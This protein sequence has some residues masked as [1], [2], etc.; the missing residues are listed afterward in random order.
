MAVL[1]GALGLLLLASASGYALLSRRLDPETSAPER[2][3]LYV[4]VGFWAAAFAASLSWFVPLHRYGLYDPPL[5]LAA[6]GIAIPA[7]SWLRARRLPPVPHGP[8]TTSDRLVLAA[9]AVVFVLFFLGIS[10]HHYTEG[11]L[12]SSLDRLSRVGTREDLPLHRLA[13]DE[14]FGNV[15]A[16]WVVSVACPIAVERL[17]QGFFAALLFLSAAA[18]GRRLTGRNWPG[19]AAGAALVLTDDVFGFEVFNQNLIGGS[20][21]MLLFLSLSRPREGASA[22]LPAFLAA[23][24]VSSRYIALAGMAVLGDAAVRAVP[25]GTVG[26]RL[27]GLARHALPFVAACLPAAVAV[28]HT[29]A[30]TRILSQRLFN[31][32]LHDAVVRTPF[33]PFPML[34]GWPLDFVVQWG[35]LGVLVTFAGWVFLRREKTRGIARQLALYAAPVLAVL[36]VQENWFEPEKMSID[37]VLSPALVAGFAA[38][39]AGVAGARG[40][41]TWLAFGVAAAVLAAVAFAG[42]SILREAAFPED[43]RVRRAYP[44]LPAETPDIMEFERERWLEWRLGPLPRSSGLLRGFPLKVED[45]GRLLAAGEDPHAAPSA[46]ELAVALLDETLLNRL[47]VLR[48]MAPASGERPFPTRSLHLDLGTRP[49]VARSPLRAQAPASPE[50]QVLDLG[51]GRECAMSPVMGYRVPFADRPIRVLVCARGEDAWVS[52]APPRIPTLERGRVAPEGT[53]PHW[54]LSEPPRLDDL[55]TAH[56]VE[57]RVPESIERV[58]VLSHIYLEPSRIYARAVTLGPDGPGEPGAPFVW[59]AN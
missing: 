54:I 13:G 14:Q 4:G 40:W 55:P 50:R 41:R 30:A 35:F 51:D 43:E 17:G 9:T 29:E 52:V 39:L 5:I 16:A 44:G 46:S 32:P 22:A 58:T 28:A 59:H 26:A 31:F 57:I 11:C 56:A 21:A 20:T 18:L 12:Y 2:W 15:V 3:A 24:L 42:R 47:D 37:L 48:A 19:L 53:P 6:V 27:R 10:D 7:A 23:M 33:L 45:V 36:L 34:I 1:A 25:S 8:A 49:S 38:G